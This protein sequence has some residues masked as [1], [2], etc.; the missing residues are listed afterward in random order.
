MFASIRI[1]ESEH[2][3]YLIRQFFYTNLT[4][5]LSTRPF[6]SMFQKK[7]IAYQLLNGIMQLHAQGFCHGDIKSENVMVTSWLW[8]MLVDIAVHKPARLPANNPSDFSFYFDTSGRRVCNIAP[9][10]FVEVVSADNS[11]LTPQMDIFSLGCV[12][13]EIFTDG[14]HLFTLASLLK[15]RGGDAS[16]VTA[17]LNNRITDVHVRAMLSSMLSLDPIS[18]FPA[19]QYLS[20]YKNTVF[21]EAYHHVLYPCLSRTVTWSSGQRTNTLYN[22]WSMIH[23]WLDSKSSLIF[24]NNPSETNT[25]TSRP[26]PPSSPADTSVAVVGVPVGEDDA[27][28][29]CTMQSLMKSGQMLKDVDGELSAKMPVKPEAIRATTSVRNVVYAPVSDDMIS[30]IYSVFLSVILS[31]IRRETDHVVKLRAI[32]MIREMSIASA[33]RRLS[34]DVRLATVTP[35]LVELLSDASPAVRSLALNVLVD[36]LES[37]EVISQHDAKLFPKYLLP[38]ISNM[39]NND[40]SPLV[41][42]CVAV[43]LARIAECSRKFAKLELDH[44][45]AKTVVSPD[46]NSSTVV[47]SAEPAFE[48]TISD[49]RGIIGEILI[50]LTVKPVNVK[51]ALLTVSDVSIRLFD[52]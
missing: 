36:V 23:G 35:Y 4:D 50:A 16:A 8:A 12:L 10:R 37:V 32:T 9:E 25:T 45:K 27:V 21:D 18:R 34:D 44:A 42:E 47:T 30:G 43:N 49:L 26:P 33:G 41:L 31:G 6:L 19:K 3:V 52:V 24:G 22:E 14:E 39:V 5:R 20:Q 28:H 29:D 48:D 46:T 7:W 13:F 15:Y 51:R 1:E 40:S 38:V 11:T 17:S 2:G